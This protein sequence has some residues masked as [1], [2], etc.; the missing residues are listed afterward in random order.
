MIDRFQKT[1]NV[2]E[3]PEQFRN[4]YEKTLIEFETNGAF[5]LKSDYIIREVDLTNAFPSILTDLLREAESISADTEAAVYTLF[6]Y[7][8]MEDRELFLRHLKHFD[9]PK[10]K[11]FLMSLLCLL[12]TV[13]RLF[14][15]L[16]HRNVPDDI[17]RATVMQYEDC[18]FIYQK[19]FNRIGLNKRYFDHLQTYVDCKMLNIGRLRFEPYLLQAPVYLLENK[20]TGKQILLLGEGKM[21][22]DG[23]FTDLPPASEAAFDAYF[24]ENE[25]SYIATPINER[26]KCVSEKCTF[27]K[28]EWTL[29][30]RPGDRCLGVHI[31]DKGALTEEAC[32]A[33][34]RRALDVF[35]ECFDYGDVK[36]FHCKSWL[37]SPELDGHL[38]SGSNLLKFA[39]KYLRYP[40]HTDGM[41]VMNFVFY[42]KGTDYTDLPEDTSLQRSLKALYLNGGYLYSYGGLFTAKV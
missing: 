31:P 5:L 38:K 39:E 3:I 25:Q 40:T 28:S 23:L 32:D 24:S 16:K 12:P 41:E 14:E 42:L 17:I 26:G 19:R 7:R 4:I 6:V 8:A 37:M 30:I 34:Y 18:V 29:R 20:S 33:S 1:L 15:K 22:D 10:D 13:S 2:N 27:N 35:K 21:R 11:Y 36:A 9:F